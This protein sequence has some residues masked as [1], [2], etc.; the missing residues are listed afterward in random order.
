MKP[1]ALLDL[2]GACPRLERLAF[3]VQ[4]H[5][6]AWFREA[7][8]RAAAA[9]AG[10]ASLVRALSLA[11]SHTSPSLDWDSG[12]RLTALAAVG[13]AFPELEELNL[14]TVF[15]SNGGFDDSG[16]WGHWGTMPQPA[17]WAPLP[18]LRRVDIRGLGGMFSKASVTGRACNA[19]LAGLAT[20][21]TGLR[22]LSVSLGD[23]RAPRRPAPASPPRSAATHPWPALTRRRPSFWP[24]ATPQR[25]TPSRA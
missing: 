15:F 23:G 2:F 3:A 17:D 9:R 1:E 10:G 4:V 20:A 21:A 19:L 6:A 24:A 25:S 13:A 12:C 18:K 22:S 5:E 7:A 11:S 8:A 16:G 14:A